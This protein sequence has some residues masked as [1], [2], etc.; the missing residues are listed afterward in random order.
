MLHFAAYEKYHYFRWYYDLSSYPARKGFDD[1]ALLVNKPGDFGW[2]AVTFQRSA[3][4][5]L[6]LKDPR[7]L[8]N[9]VLWMSNAGRHYH[10][11]N[12][13]HV[14]VLGIEDVTAYYHI[15]LDESARMN[16][17]SKRGFATNVVLS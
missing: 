16:P 14:S 1:L 5:T 12:G 17:L 10:P 8:S 13:R 4:L 11:W 7:V 3:M 2:T 6:A 9:T 15:G